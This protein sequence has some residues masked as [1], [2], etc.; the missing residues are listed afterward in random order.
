M[1]CETGH[2]KYVSVR[3]CVQLRAAKSVTLRIQ[4]SELLAARRK[5]THDGTCEDNGLGFAVNRVTTETFETMES[6]R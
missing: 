1:R 2:G 3:S 6:A 5:I 4:I